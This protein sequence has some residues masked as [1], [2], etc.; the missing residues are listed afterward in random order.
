GCKRQDSLYIF[1]LRP[2]ARASRGRSRARNSK[3]GHDGRAEKPDTTDTRVL[4]AKNMPEEQGER[5]CRGGRKTRRTR[6]KRGTAK[7]EIM[8]PEHVAKAEKTRRECNRENESGE[9]QRKTCRGF[10]QTRQRRNVSG[11]HQNPTPK[12]MPEGLKNPTH[13]AIRVSGA[14]KHAEEAWQRNNK[15]NMFSGG[16]QNPTHKGNR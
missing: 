5:I 14:G 8:T 11:A 16:R 4:E 1:P 3:G 7:R 13:N 9:Q 15:E 6:A 10:F 2:D 12:D